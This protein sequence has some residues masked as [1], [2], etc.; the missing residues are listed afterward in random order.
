MKLAPTA[1]DPAAG[2]VDKHLD[3]L[4]AAAGQRALIKELYNGC[5]SS[6]VLGQN[7][8][9]S[10]QAK[11]TTGAP[12]DATGDVSYSIYEVEETAAILSEL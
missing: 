11:D 6:C 10:V 4:A 1:G 8:T 9:F 12:V 2:S 3:D 5:P 7:L